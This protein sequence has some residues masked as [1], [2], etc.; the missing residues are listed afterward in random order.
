MAG[1]SSRCNLSH[2]LQ[3]STRKLFTGQFSLHLN[4]KWYCIKMWEHHTLRKAGGSKGTLTVSELRQISIFWSWFP[5]YNNMVFQGHKL[6]ALL[7][8][9]YFTI[10]KNNKKKNTHKKIH[11]Y[12]SIF[13]CSSLTKKLNHFQLMQLKRVSPLCR[14]CCF[15]SSGHH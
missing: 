9:L 1:S 4:V 2:K 7:P 14:H 13:L 8:S 11:I 12:F 15:N 5:R 10:K 3:I 6:F